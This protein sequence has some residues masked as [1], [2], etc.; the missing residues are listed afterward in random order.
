MIPKNW[1]LVLG[2][3]FGIGCQTAIG[4]AQ[5]DYNIFGVCLRTK[6]QKFSLK[7]VLDSSMADI[8]FAC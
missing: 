7:R 8:L 6:M 3:S 1:A 5:S 2:A 4:L